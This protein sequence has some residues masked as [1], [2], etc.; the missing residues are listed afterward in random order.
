M[1]TKKVTPAKK[2]LF[3]KADLES[4]KKEVQKISDYLAKQALVAKNHL[5]KKAGETKDY[6]Q[7]VGTLGTQILKLNA[8]LEKSY[9]KIGKLAVDKNSLTSAEIK[10]LL[11][12]AVKN[13]AQ[14][15]KKTEELKKLTK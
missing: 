3:T 4:A 7:K 9:Y 1:A 6:L 15:K 5:T 8:S 11:A 12:T 13:K 2:E 14:A 10:K